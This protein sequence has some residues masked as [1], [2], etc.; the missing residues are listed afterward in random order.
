MTDLV[1]YFSLPDEWANKAHCPVC[2]ASPLTVIHQPGIPD[3]MACPRC[4]SFFEI[5]EKGA[6]IYFTALPGILTGPLIGRWVTNAQVKQTV[7]TVVA[8]K[9]AE[10]KAAFA[11]SQQPESKDLLSPEPSPFTE[12]IV[13]MIVPAP[14]IEQQVQGKPEL[15]VAPPDLPTPIYQPDAP[16][17]KDVRTRARDLYALGNRPDQIKAILSQDA[18]LDKAEIQ[19][20]LD[21]LS[22]E[23]KTKEHRQH[24]WMWVS[25]GIGLFILIL[26]IVM[27]L[28]WQ[29]IYLKLAGGAGMNIIATLSPNK[30]AVPL[31]AAP[32][33]VEEKENGE[34]RPA[35]PKT[36]EEAS[37]LFG[38]PADSWFADTQDGSWFLVTGAAV[39]VQVP[40]GM[41]AILVN[42]GGGGVNT[43]PG[44]ASITN[45]SSLSI[46][47][48]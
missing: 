29:T 18:T 17:I 4:H 6:S 19:A 47:C 39:T 27:A 9:T 41:N 40:G 36:K 15:V 42:I 32:I 31:M 45:T 11:Q 16:E 28:T 22:G 44:P 34:A 8:R 46:L 37:A 35:C 3:Q 25:I 24:T 23:D 12:D 33:V 30:T 21:N 1:P 26:C 48:H 13:K 5:E 43:V 10:K 14:Q 38:G 20:V 2:S 7:Q